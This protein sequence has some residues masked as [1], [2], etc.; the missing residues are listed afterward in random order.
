MF[1]NHRCSHP[2]AAVQPLLHDADEL[3]VAQLVVVIL[4]KDLEDGVDQ[5]SGEFDPRGHVNSS[6]KLL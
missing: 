1:K 2:A 4:V 6:G 3:L 5:V